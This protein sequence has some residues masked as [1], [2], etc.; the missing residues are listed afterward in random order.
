MI[1]GTGLLLVTR[2]FT[3]GDLALLIV[4]LVLLAAS[5]ILALAETSLVRICLLYTSDAADE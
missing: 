2:S 4:V 3:A 1:P 5:A